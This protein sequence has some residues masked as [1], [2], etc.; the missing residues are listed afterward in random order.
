[1]LNRCPAMSNQFGA[2]KRQ[3][4][5]IN[6]C[7]RIKGAGVVVSFPVLAKA[8]TAEVSH[9]CSKRRLRDRGLEGSPK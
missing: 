1:M 5:A 9:R 4:D 8:L 6:F 7:R 3:N 2:R